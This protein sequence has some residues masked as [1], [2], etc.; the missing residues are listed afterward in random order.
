MCS[1]LDIKILTFCCAGISIFRI[2]IEFQSVKVI[3]NAII[4]KLKLISVKNWIIINVCIIYLYFRSVCFVYL[5]TYCQSQNF[6]WKF[7]LYLAYFSSEWNFRID[8][9]SLVH[10]AVMQVKCVTVVILCPWDSSPWMLY[11]NTQRLTS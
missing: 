2:T 9:L 1:K 10:E 3:N 7:G 4:S 11:H 5:F 6:V 8:H